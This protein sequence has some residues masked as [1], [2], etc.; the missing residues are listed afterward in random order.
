MS[1]ATSDWS[2]PRVASMRIVHA[3]HLLHCTCTVLAPTPALHLHLHLHLRCGC[4]CAASALHRCPPH[5]VCGDALRRLHAHPSGLRRH[6]RPVALDRW[7]DDAAACQAEQLLPTARGALADARRA[8]LVASRV[9]VSEQ[10]PLCG[11]CGRGALASEVGAAAASRAHPQQQVHRGRP[12]CDHPRVAR[13]KTLGALAR[14]L[15]A[16]MLY[17]PE[18]AALR[19]RGCRQPAC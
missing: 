1:S 14:L 5:H 11:A 8:L 4:I 19:V 7:A 6:G 15:Y 17:M 3:M 10:R 18:D 12:D 2:G 13:G 16:H 9:Q